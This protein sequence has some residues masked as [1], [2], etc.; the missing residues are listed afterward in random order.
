MRYGEENSSEGVGI[1]TGRWAFKKVG[2]GR[3]PR[4]R[5]IRLKDGSK[6]GQPCG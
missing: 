6:K 4:E 2:Q 5:S 3:L 1:G